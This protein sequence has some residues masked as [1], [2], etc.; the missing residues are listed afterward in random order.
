ML[1]SMRAFFRSVPQ[2]SAGGRCLE[3]DG[4]LAGVTPAVPERSLPN[5]VVYESEETL[6]AALDQLAATYHEAGVA[7]WTVWVP[8]HHVRTREL[9]AEAGHV[10]DASPTAMIADLASVEPPREDDP[11]PEPE[12][13]LADI[14]R[15]N[16]LAYG[17][18][19]S[20]ARVLG[21][22]PADPRSAYVARLDG[23]PA[24]SVV[25]RDHAGD[26]SIW[27]VAT[28]P[29]V[30]GRGLASGLMRRALADG[31]E[32][33]CEVTTLQAT[34]VGRPVYEGLGYRPFGAIEMWERRRAAPA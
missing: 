22:G 14:G 34:K 26:C 7:A 6:A 8:E 29:D 12:P 17:T 13:S 4:V 3:L 31:R 9:L 23:E 32:R 30:R 15:I 20:F 2:G 11:E 5:S 21:E 19:D 28:A 10:L 25:S 27:W 16:D 24:A 33:G 1:E 18:G